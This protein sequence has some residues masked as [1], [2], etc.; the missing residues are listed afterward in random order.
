MRVF[1][2]VAFF[3][4]LAALGTAGCGKKEESPAAPRAE[5]PRA[6]KV[7]AG[8]DFTDGTSNAARVP[9]FGKMKADM[10]KAAK[11]SGGRADPSAPMMDS[12]LPRADKP[13]DKTWAKPAS[14]EAKGAEAMVAPSRPH[15][16]RPP[17]K[18]QLDL[19]EGGLLTAGSFDDNLYPGP[20]RTFLKKLSREQGAQDLPSR[21]LGHR[22]EVTV[23]SGDGR[24]VGN[25][26]VQVRSEDGGPTVTLRSRTD[27][28]AIFL[29]SWDEVPADGDLVVT[30]SPPAGG[31]AVT[32]KVAREVPRCEVRLV[33]AAAPLPLHLDLLL[34]LDTT[35]S[36]ADELEYLKTELKSIVTAV[37]RQFPNV[38]QR[39]GLVVYRD[40]GDEYVTRTFPF[41]ESLAEF[42]ANLAAQRAAG[43]GDYPEAMHR[44]LE[45]TVKLDWREGPAARVA[46]LV[47]DAPP[48]AQH[49]L[50]ALKAADALRKKGV[51]IYPVAASGYD[52]ACEFVM[53]ASAVLTG[54]QFVFLTDDSGVGEKH[55][56]PHIP[57]YH[58][59]RLNQLMVRVLAGELSGRRIDPDPAQ[60]VRTVGTPPQ[61]QARR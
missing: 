57:F 40:E 28:R 43:G 60:V 30:V 50:R 5:A 18:A 54:G 61:A 32:N 51:A 7:P 23:R 35:N 17:A 10:S 55:G 34:V 52:A 11:E 56:E 21:F 4:I 25:A 45:D 9:G 48:H 29:S 22:L 53:R 46:F 14:R 36:M 20:L 26:R 44:A 13:A 16:D 8:S 19:P 59:E 58:V 1:I 15:G 49:T 39:Y 31:P 3:G 38:R 37:H 47:A 41:T 6:G 24:P 2:S 12:V 42:R 33:G 27:G